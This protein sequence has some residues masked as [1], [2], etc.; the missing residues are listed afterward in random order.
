M[1]RVCALFCPRIASPLLY[2]SSLFPV[3]CPSLPCPVSLVFVFFIDLCLLVFLVLSCGSPSQY[4]FHPVYCLVFLLCLLLY[5]HSG[6]DPPHFVSRRLLSCLLSLYRDLYLLPGFWPVGLT[7][8][9]ALSIKPLY[10]ASG[11]LIHFYSPTPYVTDVADTL[12]ICSLLECNH[13]HIPIKAPYQ[14]IV[15]IAPQFG[16]SNWGLYNRFW[17]SSERINQLHTKFIQHDVL[18]VFATIL[19][20]KYW[21]L[22]HYCHAVYFGSNAVETGDVK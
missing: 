20:N 3:P 22:A 9:S 12:H 6:S 5:W 13:I 2:R 19:H 8:I 17:F 11:S 1:F 10:T 15:V 14:Y 7:T 16:N 21:Y 18:C 4:L